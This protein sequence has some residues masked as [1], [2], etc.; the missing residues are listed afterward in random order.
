MVQVYRDLAP[1]LHKHRR[2]YLIGSFAVL[3]TVAF[4]LVSPRIL[5]LAIDALATGQ[6]SPLGWRSTRS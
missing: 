1:Y 5:A 2:Q 6:A 3:M 4:T